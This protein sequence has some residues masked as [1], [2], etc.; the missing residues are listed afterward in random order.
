M[1]YA[2]TS[3]NSLAASARADAQPPLGHEQPQLPGSGRI[4]PGSPSCHAAARDVPQTAVR[5][6]TRWESRADLAARSEHRGVA[7]AANGTHIDYGCAVC[8]VF[9]AMAR[10]RSAR[11]S[12]V[13]AGQ[14]TTDELRDRVLSRYRG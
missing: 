12:E 1:K 8:A 13:A 2:L 5:S 9:G 4:P 7:L 10:R 3:G 11:I 6:D 14:L